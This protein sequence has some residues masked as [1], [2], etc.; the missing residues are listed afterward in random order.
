MNFK[1]LKKKPTILT[2][3]AQSNHRLKEHEKILWHIPASFHKSN[4][5]CS[6]RLKIINI[7]GTC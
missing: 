3:M 5:Q 7:T 6:L 1:T 2:N 4:P